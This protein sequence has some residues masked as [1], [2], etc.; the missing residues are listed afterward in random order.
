ML[1]R[2]IDARLPISV[3]CSEG[4]MIYGGVVLWRI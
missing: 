1:T 3:S 4:L 2:P